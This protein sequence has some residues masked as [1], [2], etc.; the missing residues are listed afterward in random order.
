MTVGS[1]PEEEQVELRVVEFAR[2]V[3]GG[4]LLSELAF[5][6]VHFAR[7]AL[8]IVE[9]RLLRRAVVRVVV[10]WRHATLVAPPKR[11]AAPVGRFLRRLLVCTLRR[12]AAR[13]DDISTFI[14]SA[15]KTLCDHRRDLVFALDDDEL[16]VA[17]FHSSPAASSRE[18]SIAA[19]IAFRNAARTPACSSSRIA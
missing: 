6:P 2:V 17:T 5:D 13:E 11:N 15:R 12:L 4:A 8:E 3:G 19:W 1:D 7:P 14:D 16:D 10:L 18:R 9:Q